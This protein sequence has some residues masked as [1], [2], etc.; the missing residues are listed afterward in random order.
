LSFTATIGEESTMLGEKISDETFKTTGRRVLTVEG[1]P[2]METSAQAI[3]KLYGVDYQM[4]VTYTG[5]LRA[6]GVIQQPSVRGTD[7]PFH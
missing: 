6:D 5:K 2:V 3:G 1:E 7:S 4:F